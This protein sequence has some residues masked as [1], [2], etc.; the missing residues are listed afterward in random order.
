MAVVLFFGAAGSGKTTQAG[1]LFASLGLPQV[2]F[3]DVLREAISSGALNGTKAGQDMADDVLV[4]LVAKKVSS[5][6]YSRGFT[7]EGFP[8]SIN[9]AILLDK[10]LA[11]RG[12]STIA[13]YLDIG[14]QQYETNSAPLLTY[15]RQHGVL[16]QIVGSNLADE[17]ESDI[18]R[19]INKS[20]SHAPSDFGLENEQAEA[21][22]GEASR[23]CDLD[24]L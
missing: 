19:F 1:R 6:I 24:L 20:A 15:Y 12:Q 21:F 11:R 3:S 5:E 13:I 8:S 22:T 4:N 14:D 10:V 23:Q 17:V 16:V 2:I 9:Q 18:L 7:L